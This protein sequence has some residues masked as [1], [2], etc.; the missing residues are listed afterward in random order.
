[1]AGDGSTEATASGGDS[2]VAKTEK[3]KNTRRRCSVF[4]GRRT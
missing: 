1:V 4:I 3:K 2:V